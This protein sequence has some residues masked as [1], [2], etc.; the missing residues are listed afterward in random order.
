MN[1]KRM[2]TIALL[3]SSSSSNFARCDKNNKDDDDNWMNKFAKKGKDALGNIDIKNG[4]PKDFSSIFNE[5]IINK[6]S[7]KAHELMEGGLPVQVSYGFMMGYSSGYCLKKVSKIMAFA[8]GG[9]FIAVQ[10]LSYNGYMIVNYEKVQKDVER[11]MDLNH[12]G[13]VDEKD[14]KVA[15]E[16]IHDVLSYN[17][18]TGGGFGAGLLMG[19]RS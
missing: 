13:K 15:Y 14:A 3:L 16:K 12:D 19:L 17:M 2:F 6:A 9:V 5:D 18:P 10:S 4:I 7:A 8:L 11:L 1:Y